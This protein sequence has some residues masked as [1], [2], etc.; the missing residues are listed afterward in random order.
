[1]LFSVPSPRVWP[2][3]ESCPPGFVGQD[4]CGP[5]VLRLVRQDLHRQAWQVNSVSTPR[6]AGLIGPHECSITGA[7]QELGVD[8]RTQQRVA[9]RP[10]EAPQPL[11][12]RRRQAK[13]RHLDV[14]ALHTP[15]Y[16]VKRLL[17]AAMLVL[18][19]S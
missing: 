3:A 6:R 12:L 9:R 8:Q 15:K 1:M 11:R 18:P 14:L 10:I 17:C 4:V 13:S 5:S 16:V 2:R 7:K 19:G